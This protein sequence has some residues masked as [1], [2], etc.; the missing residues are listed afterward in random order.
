MPPPASSRRGLPGVATD[1][2]STDGAVTGPSGPE[3]AA[4]PAPPRSLGD[5][6]AWVLLAGAGFVGGQIA[7]ALIL[8]LV[9][10]ADG[11]LNDLSTLEARAVPPA[12]VVV[13]GLVGLWAGFVGAAV[14]A[15][16]WRGSGHVAR[17]LG[18]RVRRWDPVIGAVAGLLGQFVLV[19]VLYLPWEHFDPRLSRQLSQPAKHLTGGFPGS[20]LVVIGVLTVA[21]VPVV[22]ELFFRG[23]VLRGCL[24]LFDGAGRILGPTLAVLVTGVVFGLAHAE[25]LELLGLAGFGVVLSAMAYRWKRLGPGIFAHAMFNLVAIV[26]VAHQS[27]MLR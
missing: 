14:A 1:V 25:L 15:S 18:L 19:T 10:S 11:H 8:V 5:A 26:S 24:R 3:G 9:A 4:A 2:T 12:W 17:D 7:A 21:V 27:G 6:A 22:E 13:G 16:R 23:L 20:D